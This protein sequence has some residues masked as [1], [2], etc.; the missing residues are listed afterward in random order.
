MPARE[1]G[2][3]TLLGGGAIPREERDS[4]IEGTLDMVADGLLMGS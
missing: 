1:H 4:V 3:A 2:A